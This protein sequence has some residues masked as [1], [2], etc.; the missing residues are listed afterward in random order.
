MFDE[1]PMGSQRPAPICRKV[2]VPAPIGDVWK[3]WTTSQG[4]ATF[5]APAAIIEAEVGGAY[6]LYFMPDGP[7]G[8][9][10]SEGCRIHSME[11]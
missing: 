3:A 11:E 5:F 8:S 9:R 2:E 10:G 1:T 7:E 4:A 6:E